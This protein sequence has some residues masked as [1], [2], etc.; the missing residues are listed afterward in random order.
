[1]QKLILACKLCPGD[2]LTMTAAVESLHATY[3]DEYLT[4]TRTP[5]PDIWRHN[6]HITPTP[7]DEKAKDVRTIQMHYPRISQSNQRLHHFLTGYTTFLGQRIERPLELTTNRPHL[8][9]SDDET[10]WIDQIRD[11]LT[12]GRQVP[13]WLFCAGVKSDY[14]AKQWP[15]E[16]YQTVIDETR[17]RI[18]WV[19]IG[20]AGHDHPD[21][22]GVIDMR[23]RTDTRQL[24]RL[25]HH[26]QGGLG[27]ATLLMHLCAAWE[28][29]YIALLG[30][31]EPVPWNCYP[32]QLTLHTV[33][34]LDCC[35]DA[36]C[37]KARVVPLE[38]NDEAKN[39][40]LC[41]Q[42]VMGLRRPVGR[43]M[44]LIRPEQVLLALDAYTERRETA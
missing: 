16:S 41:E 21:L 44:A 20:E 5:V 26:A 4:D 15:V 40:S 33:G 31:R 1:M 42:P 23:G 2:V 32:L 3:P 8:Y 34:M 18:Q 30:G 11:Q 6:P 9:L 12:H 43:C 25:A 7:L 28:K 39:A 10:K 17:G 24:I 29:P 27:P 37:W 14:T 22:E 36:A 19:Q 35:R 38:D 13:F